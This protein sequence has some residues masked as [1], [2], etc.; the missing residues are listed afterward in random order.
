[1]NSIFHLFINFPSVYSVPM[2]EIVFLSLK[3]NKRD[4]WTH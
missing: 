4:T 1:M 2:G 3:L